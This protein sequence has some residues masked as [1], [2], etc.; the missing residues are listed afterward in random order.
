MEERTMLIMHQAEE[1]MKTHQ[2]DKAEYILLHSLDIEKTYEQYMKLGKLYAL[3]MNRIE[4]AAA[5]FQKALQYNQESTEANSLTGEMLFRIGRKQ[6]ALS[7]LT[8]AIQGPADPLQYRAYYFLA[9]LYQNWN[10]PERSVRFLNLCLKCKS[11]YVPAVKMLNHLKNKYL[12]DTAVSS[13]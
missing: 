6:E 2:Q 11:D 10:R 4:E 5:V 12:P 3:Y 13:F 7:Y 1:L 9:I 8:R